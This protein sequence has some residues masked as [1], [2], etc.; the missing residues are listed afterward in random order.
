MRAKWDG[1]LHPHELP[2]VPCM[3]HPTHTAG[4]EFVETM[5]ERLRGRAAMDVSALWALEMIAELQR[6]WFAEGDK[7]E[8][9]ER[10]I[11]GEEA[12]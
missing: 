3:V 9:I 10:I 4:Y 8:A 7:V 5:I 11:R 2:V 12:I 6:L 1:A